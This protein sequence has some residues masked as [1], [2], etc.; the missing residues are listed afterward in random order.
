MTFKIPSKLHLEEKQRI[1]FPI[2]KFMIITNYSIKFY[3]FLSW[4]TSSEFLEMLEI[5]GFLNDFSNAQFYQLFIVMQILWVTR[6]SIVIYWI[7]WIFKR[8]IVRLNYER[9]KSR[10]RSPKKCRFKK[11]TKPH[12]I[13]NYEWINNNFQHNLIV[14]LSFNKKDKYFKTR[15]KIIKL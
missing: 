5:V 9:N 10:K 4:I 12:K 11:Q 3:V 6:K 8:I 1:S 14:F 2:D 15:N 13:I 7:W